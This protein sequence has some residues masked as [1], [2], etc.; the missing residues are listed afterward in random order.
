[1]AD[2]FIA[3]M[4]KREDLSMF[5]KT[6]ELL[7]LYDDI[8]DLSIGE[9]DMTTPEP[10]IEASYRDSLAGHT[11]YTAFR[12]DPQLRAQICKVYK[13]DYDIDVPD[14]EVLVVTS[15]NMGMFVTLFTCLNPGDEVL[16]PDPCFPIYE[17]QARF[18]NAKVVPV[19]T[20]ESENF[21]F[22]TKIAEK[23]VTD[24]TKALIINTPCNPTGACMTLDDMKEIAAFAKKHD[25]LVISDDIYTSMSFKETFVPIISLPE[26]RER[27]V[28]INSVSKN[29]IMTGYRLGWII[30]PAYLTDAIRKTNDYM[31]FTAPDP[32][33]RAAL[34]AL[35][36]REELM[37]P[38]MNEFKERVFLMAE[39]INTIK[40]LSVLPP[41]GTFYLFMNI[42]ETGLTSEEFAY[43]VL[44]KAHVFFLAGTAFGEAGEGYVRIACT[45]DKKQ[46]MEAMDRVE[47]LNL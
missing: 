40:N 15:A 22:N 47:K 39:R 46:L 27:T 7:A 25:L 9:P 5:A 35:E 26:M 28:V 33:Q 13:E 20:F 30:A 42:K 21:R 37:A 29:F 43:K 8:I 34:Y 31:V 11:H 6:E 3:E 17:G 38:V 14:E 45:R 23:Y 18:C 16:V 36:H 19:A 1:M 41:R 4:H 12:G 44:E 32:S 24:K 2:K 10:I